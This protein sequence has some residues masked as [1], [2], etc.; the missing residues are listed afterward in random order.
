MAISLRERR[1]Q[2]LRDEI[3]EAAQQLISDQGY[4]AVS[5]EEL[6]ARVG[7]S[8]P[9]L[10]NQFSNKEQLVVA[11]ANQV[12]ERLLPLVDDDGAPGRSP[13]DRLCDLLLAAVQMQL[14]RRVTAMQLW[15][16]EVVHMLKE[17]QEALDQICKIDAVVVNLVRKALASGEIIP[18]LDEFSVVR[19]FYALF[20]SPHVGRL[21]VAGAINPETMPEKVVAFFRRGLGPDPRP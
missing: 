14:D 7:I 17:H 5:M 18:L 3:L 2:M 1:R 21:S 19:I 12:M 13:M 9:T 10:Y 4:A 6:A 20:L 8:K 16:P 11:M 15:M